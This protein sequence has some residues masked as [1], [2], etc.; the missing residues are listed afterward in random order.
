MSWVDSNKNYKLL[1]DL[2]IVDVTLLGNDIRNSNP[3][4]W[5]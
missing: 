5:C 4:L 1:D 2:T 3:E